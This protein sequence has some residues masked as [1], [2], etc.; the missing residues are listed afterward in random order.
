MELHNFN[1]NDLNIIQTK[2]TH[3]DLS[4]LLS[5]ETTYLNNDIKV[6]KYIHAENDILCMIY[7]EY[8]NVH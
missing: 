1:K 4:H 2:V 8:G 7:F 3:S 5:W 6:I